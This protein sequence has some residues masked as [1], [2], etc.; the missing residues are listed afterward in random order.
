M[1]EEKETLKVSTSGNILKTIQSK[2]S[3][4]LLAVFGLLAIGKVFG[5]TTLSWWVISCPLWLPF[6]IFTGFCGFL[7]G[8]FVIWMILSFAYIIVLGLIS[9]IFSVVKQEEF[10]KKYKKIVK[11]YKEKYKN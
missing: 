5:L 11:D 1:S 6:A 8:L 3:Y 4:I 7:L 9:V 10:A 2:L